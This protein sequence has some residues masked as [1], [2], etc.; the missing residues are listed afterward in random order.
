ML[1]LLWL[2]FALAL[3]YS[4]TSFW[5]SLDLHPLCSIHFVLHIFFKHNTLSTWWPS[6]CSLMVFSWLGFSYHWDFLSNISLGRT[7]QLL[8]KS[9]IILFCLLIY[10]LLFKEWHLQN[11]AAVQSLSSVWLIVTLWTVTH[12]ASLSF[13]P[14][15]FS[16]SC[17][18]SQ[19]CHPHLILY[20][21]L[22][23]MPSILPSIR[24]FSN[25][26]ALCIKWPRYCSF[27]FSISPCPS[28][29]QKLHENKDLFIPP[30]PRTIR[31]KW[32]FVEC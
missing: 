15:V 2:L 11:I 31:T 18:L 32:I 13:A 19:C 7:S 20:Y 8:N 17:P 5:T 23:L 21:P 4:I 9:K 10:F 24:V 12:Q 22:F 30:S 14:T 26:S 3:A 6:I 25:E 1:L 28:L 16:N 27:S 29:K